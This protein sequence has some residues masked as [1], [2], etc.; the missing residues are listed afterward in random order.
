MPDSLLHVQAQGHGRTRVYWQKLRWSSTLHGTTTHLVWAENEGFEVE[1]REEVTEATIADEI[2]AAA[3][4]ARR[5]ALDEHPRARA[6][7]PGRGR[8][9]RDRLLADGLLVNVPKRKGGFNL[10][11]AETPPIPFRAGNG[12]GTVAVPHPG[13]GGRRRFR[14]SVPPF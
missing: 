4:G 7:P 11:S 8:V 12:S 2:L 13:E 14:S 1:E 5:P 6:R 10:W 3:P 9:R